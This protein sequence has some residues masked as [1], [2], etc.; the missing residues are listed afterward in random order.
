M[1][2][3]LLGFKP[4]PPF[5]CSLFVLSV[6]L[7]LCYGSGLLLSAAVGFVSPKAAVFGFILPGD[8][9]WSSCTIPVAS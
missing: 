9:S 4:A 1:H 6:L 2:P 3:V 5:V 8:I 7:G